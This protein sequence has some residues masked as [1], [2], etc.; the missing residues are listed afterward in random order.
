MC[1]ALPY[2]LPLGNYLLAAGMAWLLFAAL[3]GGAFFIASCFS[4]ASLSDAFGA[5]WTIVAFVLDVIPVV[6]YVTAG[7]A[8][9]VAPLLPAGNRGYRQD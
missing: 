8:Q 4:R 3:G 2:E 7:V 5:A 9:P 6:A 1:S